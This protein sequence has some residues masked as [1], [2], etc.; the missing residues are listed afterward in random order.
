MHEFNALTRYFDAMTCSLSK[1]SAVLTTQAVCALKNATLALN[2]R[3]TREL[4]AVQEAQSAEMLSHDREEL[5]LPKKPVKVTRT[6]S[7]VGNS[8]LRQVQHCH[9]CL[10]W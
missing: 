3:L 8:V 5:A 2:L 9:A 6:R 10:G 4:L 7:G 1:T